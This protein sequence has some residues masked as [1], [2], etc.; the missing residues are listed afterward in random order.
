VEHKKRKARKALYAGN[1]PVGASEIAA[2]PQVR[3][4]NMPS[5]TTRYVNIKLVFN[6]PRR[7][8]N[9]WLAWDRDN[10]RLVNSKEAQA[11]QINEPSIMSWIMGHL[12]TVFGPLP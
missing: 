2:T 9:F 7:K 6:A 11:L 10:Q 4:F 12:P 3:L 5:S 8:A 1:V